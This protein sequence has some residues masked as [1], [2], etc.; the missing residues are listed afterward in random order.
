ME[1]PWDGQWYQ[2]CGEQEQH[3]LAWGRDGLGSRGSSLDVDKLT[4]VSQEE[5][6]LLV[7]CAPK[8]LGNGRLVGLGSLNSWRVGLVVASGNQDKGRVDVLNVEEEFVLLVVGVQGS[9]NV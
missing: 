4:T 3:Q 8:V 5:N 6:E 1:Q 9:S 2:R 7:V